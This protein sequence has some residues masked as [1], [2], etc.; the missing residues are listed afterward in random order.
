MPLPAG[1]TLRR[2]LKGM[3]VTV[4]GDAVSNDNQR[5]ADRARDG[6]DFEICL[7]QIAESIEVVHFI[8]NKKER[9]LGI[10]GGR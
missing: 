7:R 10:V 8:L 3:L 5:I 9:V 4:L 2:E 6:E 1:H